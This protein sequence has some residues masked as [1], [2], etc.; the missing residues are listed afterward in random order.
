MNRTL[1]ALLLPLVLAACGDIPDLIYNQQVSSTFSQSREQFAKDHLSFLGGNFDIRSQ[2]ARDL[3]LEQLRK[4][5]EELELA[6][7]RVETLRHSDDADRFSRHLSGYYELQVGY[8]QNLR[9]YMKASD[10]TKKEGIAQELKASYVLLSAA[11]ERILLSQKR[12][13]EKAGLTP[14]ATTPDASS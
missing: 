7:D 2:S 3:K 11:P 5:I 8:Y 10:K 9:R 1:A 12:F 6:L 13:L 14:E 4:H